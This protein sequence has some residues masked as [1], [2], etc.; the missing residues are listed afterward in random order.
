VE[1]KPGRAAAL[2][3]EKRRITM[4][5]QIRNFVFGA[6]LTALLW[7]P[8]LMAQNAETAQIP[9]G[10]HVGQS[11]LPAG[12]YSVTNDNGGF[13]KIRNMDTNNSILLGFQ[14]RE[15]AQNDP[16]LT[17]RCYSGDCFLSAVWMPGYS[18]YSFMKSGREK[19]VANGGAQLAMTYVPLA[20]R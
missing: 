16:H 2:R 8:S 14:G 19:E 9:F 3:L 13:L 18:G 5:N 7:S 11:T 6:G 12:N 10:F 17:F 15:T 20:T 4:K 1:E